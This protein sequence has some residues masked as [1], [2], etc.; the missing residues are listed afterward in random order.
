MELG[1]DL[2]LELGLRPGLG[3]GLELGLGLGLGLGFV[4]GVVVPASSMAIHICIRMMC[5]V[6]PASAMASRK[7]SERPA[8]SGWG[9]VMWCAS[10]V[11]AKPASSQ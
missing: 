8:P 11:A 10:Q 4:L 5:I 2:R 3:L 7:H 9:V 6:V 1:R